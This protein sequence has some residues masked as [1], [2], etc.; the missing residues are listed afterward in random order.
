MIKITTIVLSSL[1]LFVTVDLL[2]QCADEANIY[3]FE[4][5]GES[6]EVVKE[7]QT[8]ENAAACAL[9]RG[10][11]LAE[12]NSQSEQ[13]AVY[14]GVLSAGID[15]GNTIAPDGGGASYVW[16]GGNDLLE[17]SKWMWDG[18]NGGGGTHFFQGTYPNGQPV[19]DAYVNW[20]N[21]PDN[22][23]NQDALGLA[24]TNWPLGVAGQWN[25]VAADNQLYYVI[26]LMPDGMDE[27]KQTDV[28]IYPNPVNNLLFVKQTQVSKFEKYDIYNTTGQLKYSGCLSGDNDKINVGNIEH[29]FYVLKLYS[30]D[31]NITNARFIK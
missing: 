6:Y 28:I 13:D 25:D 1:L 8:W 2:A 17:E 27:Q 11:A 9:E 20:G 10:G 31:G 22:W 29:G 7:N 21:E 16:L 24:I 5:E 12:I 30:Q 14:D 19:D 26:E 4:Y 15:V 18:A 23:G 3:S